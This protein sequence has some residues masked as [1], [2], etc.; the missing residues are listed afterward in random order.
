[1]LN[2]VYSI[3]ENS[4]KSRFL[5]GA[6]SLL[7]SEYAETF[8]PFGLCR[9]PSVPVLGRKLSSESIATLYD[10]NS[11]R[12]PYPI[13]LLEKKYRRKSNPLK[14]EDSAKKSKKNTNIKTKSKLLDEKTENKTFKNRPFTLSKV[15]SYKYITNKNNFNHTKKIKRSNSKISVANFDFIN[16]TP[17]R[18]KSL[19]SLVTKSLKKHKKHKQEL[20][21][22]NKIHQQ[23]SELF[24]KNIEELNKMT[25]KDNFLKFKQKVFHPKLPWG[26]DENR[27]KKSLDQKKDPKV[28]YIDIT[29]PRKVKVSKRKLIEDPFGQVYSKKSVHKASPEIK[30][31]LK[32]QKKIRKKSKEIEEEIKLEKE[33][34]RISQL[35]YLD[36]VT[37]QLAEKPKKRKKI[38]KK[39]LKRVPEKKWL[40][41][42]F[43][44]SSDKEEKLLKKNLS[45]SDIYSTDEIN[46][47]QCKAFGN[48][49]NYA[50]LNSGVNSTELVNEILSK[51]SPPE[52]EIEKISVSLPESNDLPSEK[53]KEIPRKLI[54]N[55]K[56]DVFTFKSKEYILKNPAELSEELKGLKKS[57]EARNKA[58]TKIQAWMRGLL[59]RKAAKELSDS[60]NQKKLKILSDSNSW[61]YRKQYPDSL[62]SFPEED[63]EVNKILKSL[64]FKPSNLQ[65]LV[66]EKSID[67]VDQKPF[68]LNSDSITLNQILL[69]SP[70]PQAKNMNL[71]Q[72]NKRLLQE[73]ENLKILEQQ[74]KEI[75]NLIIPGLLKPN[76]KED[77]DALRSRD[78]KEI[79]Q[80]ALRTGSEPE[81]LKIFQS[82]IDRRYEKINS[83]FDE[84]IKAVKDALASSIIND[85]KSIVDSIE[86]Y[87]SIIEL[88]LDD[89]QDELDLM[90]RQM[91]GTKH[92][93]EIEDQILKDFH[94][95]AVFSDH[96][97][98]EPSVIDPQFPQKPHPMAISKKSPEPSVPECI[99]SPQN[100][101]KS[102]NIDKYRHSKI[103]WI[104]EVAIPSAVDYSDV[105][106]TS[107]IDQLEEIVYCDILD[108]IWYVPGDYI[109]QLSEDIIISILNNEILMANEDFKNLLSQE[110]VMSFVK[111]IFDCCGN[112]LVEDL[113]SPKSADFLELLSK[114][115][116]SEIGCSLPVEICEPKIDPSAFFKLTEQDSDYM[117]IFKKMVFDCINET[118]YLLENKTDLPWTGTRQPQYKYQNKAELLAKVQ[119]ILAKWN[120]PKSGKVFIKDKSRL[121]EEVLNK[122]NE[123]IVLKILAQETYEEDKKWI[124]Y[125]FE[126]TQVK[127]DMADIVLEHLIEE[128]YFNIF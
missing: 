76:K 50:I 15:T 94:S 45:L 119:S 95:Q 78:L 122:Q 16:H 34:R 58:A 52:V 83:F 86:S 6:P 42:S 67:S 38:K 74:N 124:E 41:Q 29:P 10:E 3:D 63:E 55:Q 28:K 18:K 102:K 125:N 1:M 87:K 107:T 27:I 101:L 99:Q 106:I 120:G 84:N 39:T 25:R 64:K 91:I 118:L 108:L 20:E 17:E 109:S 111:E 9:P 69:L 112:D 51:K 97:S 33:N 126:E 49:D 54:K 75:E 4:K 13:K 90:L 72:F 40:N 114:M 66:L 53:S 82:I 24:K 80:I 11:S 8:H 44:G 47:R 46:G 93:K 14:F 77:L 92:V 65:N 36:V 81:I 85:E 88:N 59:A 113:N 48:F 68:E 128:L 12:M 117:C 70:V 71:N 104:D 79:K 127:L 103:I 100:L 37:R 57:N 98:P 21:I 32:D 110:S 96:E 31:Y 123:E 7:V 61:M 121:S 2:E 43:S 62:E 22:K 56:P 26:A 73:Q 105:L 115:E 23:K 89:N 116:E 35:K 60:L 30:K 5:T 19:K